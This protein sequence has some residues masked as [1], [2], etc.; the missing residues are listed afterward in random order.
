MA[1][2]SKAPVAGR[3]CGRQLAGA[4][5]PPT[6]CTP[7]CTGMS[8][9]TG[10]SCMLTPASFS[11][12]SAPPPAGAAPAPRP[13]LLPG[14]TL[15]GGATPGRGRTAGKAA[16]MRKSCCCCCCCCWRCC[17]CCCCCCCWH[18]WW[19]C[20]C[21]G[22]CSARGCP[23]AGCAARAGEPP[24]LPIATMLCALVRSR[25]SCSL[26]IC[27][28]RSLLGVVA[29]RA[30]DAAAAAVADARRCST[31]ASGSAAAAGE[32]AALLRLAAAVAGCSVGIQTYFLAGLPAPEA[33]G[34]LAAPSAAASRR[35]ISPGRPVAVAAAS[36]ELRGW[37][38]SGDGW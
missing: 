32:A 1:L 35:A 13:L 25:L 33:P 26:R 12:T 34:L 18:C 38:A 30:G 5:L 17:C 24:L 20:C 7:A 9:N 4:S 16:G 10:D 19:W 15:R 28:R 3:C 8:S 14:L 11:S 21:C 37:C 23:L 31:A 22:R 6:V 36:S 2:A 27:S 29:S